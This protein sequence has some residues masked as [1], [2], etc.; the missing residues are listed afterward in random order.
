M[1]EKRRGRPPR[2]PEERMSSGSAATVRL[3]PRQL[4]E[5]RTVC[6]PGA[7][8]GAWLRDLALGYVAGLRYSRLEA[9]AEIIERVDRGE[10]VVVRPDDGSPPGQAVEWLRRAVAS[11]DAR[12]L[13]PV[14][15]RAS[16]PGWAAIV[17]GMPEVLLPVVG[18]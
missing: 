9:A 5:L 11:G 8:I 15:V 4:A 1:V 6:P 17:P 7:S 13:P 12:E 14:T 3:T 2:P 16:A 18:D 10:L